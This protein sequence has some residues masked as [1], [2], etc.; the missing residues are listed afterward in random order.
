MKVGLLMEA[1]QSQQALA[2]SA[3]E[4]LRE[5]TGSLDS[6]VRDE[7]RSTLIEELQALTDDTRRAAE[8]L[9]RLQRAAG[10]RAASWSVGIVV[11]ATVIPL[12]AV[13]EI[14]PSS[15]DIASLRTTRDQ[16]QTTIDRL[17][18]RGGQAALRRCGAAQRL[19]VRI[20]RSA[21]A[22]GDGG[23]YLVVKGY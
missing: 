21:P 16:L 19:C 3:L 1:A 23:D 12:L 15:S 18:A 22:Y 8:S 14:L 4:H 9:E 7:I 5:H 13:R 11:F 17:N 10:L 20:D 6:V 2:T